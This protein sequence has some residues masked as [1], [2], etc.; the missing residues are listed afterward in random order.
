MFIPIEEVPWTEG[1]STVGE[2]MRSACAWPCVQSLALKQK[3]DAGEQ[4]RRGAVTFPHFVG[5]TA[6]IK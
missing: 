6:V 5:H 3:R 4:M 2:Y 1:F